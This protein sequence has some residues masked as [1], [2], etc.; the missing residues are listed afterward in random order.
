MTGREKCPRCGSIAN[1]GWQHDP[2]RIGCY[3]CGWYWP[4]A[5]G[6]QQEL[7]SDEDNSY[8]G[9]LWKFGSTELADSYEEEMK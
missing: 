8:I 2:H 9:F 1:C 6:V 7:F 5:P 4:A 3:R